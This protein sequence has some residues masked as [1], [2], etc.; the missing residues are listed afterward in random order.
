MK[1]DNLIKKSKPLFDSFWCKMFFVVLPFFSEIPFLMP[2][3]VPLMKIGVVWA[4]LCLAYDLFTE[5]NI[6][7]TRYMGLI[8]LFIIGMAVSVILN[9]NNSMSK[10]NLIEFFYTSAVLVVLFPAK[11]LNNEKA[12]KE[13]TIINY[14]LAT[15]TFIVAIISLVMFVMQYKFSITVNDYTYNLGCYQGRLVGLYKNAIYPT[16][17]FGVWC[18]VSQLLINSKRIMKKSSSII[19]KIFFSVCIAVS[20][21]FVVLQNSKG[22]FIGCMGT[23]VCLVFFA[24]QS[25]DTKKFFKDKKMLKNISTVALC[26]VCLFVCFVS[27]YAIRN[28]AS[29]C[30]V[31]TAKLTNRLE[32]VEN[33]VIENDK[34]TLNFDRDVPSEY[35]FATGR[36]YIWKSSLKHFVEKPIFGYGPYSLSGKIEVYPGSSE[37]VSHFHNIFVQVLVSVGAVGFTLFVLLFF[38]IVIQVLKF[39]FKEKSENFVRALSPLGIIIFLF[40]IN[41]ADTT[42]LFQTKHSGFVFFIYLGYLVATTSSDKVLFFDK[43]IRVVDSAVEKTLSKIIGSK[44]YEK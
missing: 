41:L 20:W 9:Y 32:A 31:K 42:I 37:R 5:R 35:G 3:L 18:S 26:A 19:S 44:R 29:Y 40:I 33:I 4:F 34:E 14:T 23:I 25:V 8:V 12:I 13:I 6:L 1:M 7:K 38:L 11:P 24:V 43:P 22:I 10:M 39:L 30:V 21:T 16:A 15:L 2:Y 36:T 27:I 28:V 17:A